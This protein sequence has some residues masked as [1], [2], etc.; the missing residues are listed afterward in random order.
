MPEFVGDTARR[1]D[2]DA[3]PLRLA[4]PALPGVHLTCQYR[5]R[6]YEKLFVYNTGHALAAY[7]GWLR[8][9]RTVDAA[10]GDPLVW[11]VVAGALLATRRAI[12]AAYPG[13]R[14]GRDH[15]DGDDV[16]G[17]VADALA[18]YGNSELADPIVRVAR[19]PIR[20]LAPGDRLLGP[21]ALLGATTRRPPAS[22]VLGVAAVLLY[23]YGDE[24]VLSA[25]RS[26]RRLRRLLD[27]RGVFTVLTG[28]CGLAVDDPFTAAVAARYRGFW[29]AD[30]TWFPPA[31]PV[32][33][34][35]AAFPD[36]VADQRERLF[37][38]VAW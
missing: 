11:P 26:A 21:V 17:P 37:E 24:A 5:A 19:D 33:S 36:A 8:G 3:G 32:P 34:P 18:R 20:K 13:L 28:I 9:H 7:L 25:D 14:L 38:S 35:A 12:L 30:D 15:D 23:G 22:F 10:I 1:L 6:L 2:V 31:V 29:Y 27:E 4:P 16:H